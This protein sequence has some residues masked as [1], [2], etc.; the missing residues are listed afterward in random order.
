[1]GVRMQEKQET[2]HSLPPVGWMAYCSFARVMPPAR[3]EDL[4]RKDDDTNAH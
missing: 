3:L 1:M 4:N 2:R